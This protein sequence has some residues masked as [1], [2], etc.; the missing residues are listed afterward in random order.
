M[1][2]AEKTPLRDETKQTG[3]SLSPPSSRRWRS[4]LPPSS[5]EAGTKPLAAEKTMSAVADLERGLS[6]EVIQAPESFTGFR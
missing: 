6:R 4:R 2:N 3:P 1:I 5:P